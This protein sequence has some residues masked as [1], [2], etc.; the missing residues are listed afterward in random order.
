MYPIQRFVYRILKNFK[1]LPQTW[2]FIFRYGAYTGKKLHLKN[3][4]E[5]NEK[6]IWLKLYYHPNILTQLADKYKVREYIAT[7]IGTSYLNELYGFYETPEAIDFDSLPK[8]F[9]IKVNHSCRKN[10]IITDRSEI[11]IPKIKKTLHQWLR[12]DQYKK[13]GFEWAYK[14]IKPGIVIEKFLTEENFQHITDYK[15]HCF[16]GKVK[17]VHLIK[18]QNGQQHQAFYN[19]HFEIFP[20]N[21]TS[22]KHWFVKDGEVEKPALFD[23]M[24]HLA[25]ILADRFPFVRIDFY[26]IEQKIIFGEITFYPGDA[27]FEFI[28]DSYNKIIGDFLTLPQLE[29]GQ[30][31]IVSY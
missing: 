14:N 12:Y 13:V 3:P 29:K 11:D 22:K 10:I 24:V 23:K 8:Q 20:C 9:V 19:E 15:F 28:P 27:K 26:H 4:I 6:L 7:K 5:I 17:I 21:T 25:E 2:F 16:N 30:K 31:E 1:F 18:E